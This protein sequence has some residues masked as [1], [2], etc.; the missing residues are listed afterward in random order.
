MPTTEVTLDTPDGPMPAYQATPDAG[1]ARGGVVV[2]QEAFGVT[3]H[4]KD[5]ARRFAAAG[6]AAVAPDLFHRDGSPVVAYDDIP[7]VMPLLGRLSAEGI[8][9][10]VDAALAQLATLGFGPERSAIVGFCMGGSVVFGTAVRRSLGAAATFYGGG[11]A[12]GRFGLPN[13]LEVGADL[14]TPWLGL[15]GD[16]D[17]GI[18]VDEVERLRQVVAEAKVPAEVVRYPDADHGFHCND[19]PAVFNQAAAADGWARTLAWFDAHV[20]AG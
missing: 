12:Q 19:R 11:I 5:V 6:W 18:P 15:Y 8:A 13:Q 14:Q 9:A 16:L 10:D 4:I 3:E 2:I 7:S 1:G 17:Q 20:A